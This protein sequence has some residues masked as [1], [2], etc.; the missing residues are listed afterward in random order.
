MMTT[1]NRLTAE[2]ITTDQIRALRDEA[3]EA[4]DDR[5]VDYCDVAL[6]PFRR[7]NDDGSE[8][9]WPWNGLPADRDVARQ[10]CAEAIIAARAQEGT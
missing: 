6:A 3:V 7:Q 4:G 8:L 9:Q 10:V 2:A 1:T 5:Q